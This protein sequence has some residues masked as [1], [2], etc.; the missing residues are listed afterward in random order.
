MNDLEGVFLPDDGTDPLFDDTIIPPPK[1]KPAPLPRSKKPFCK[2][3]LSSLQDRRFD[4]LFTPAG[5][6]Y[7][8]L[9]IETRRGARPVRLTNGLA[10]EIGI[11]RQHKARYLRELEGLGLVSVAERDGAK[12]PLVEVHPPPE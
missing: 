11:V 8:R 12:V 1:A 4:V 9:E 6:L 7:Y 10:A 2:I 3:T 5:R